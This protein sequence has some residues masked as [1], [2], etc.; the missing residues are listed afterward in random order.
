MSHMISIPKDMMFG[1]FKEGNFK[2]LEITNEK[3]VV[4]ILPFYNN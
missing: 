2:A 1:Y 4:S 3:G